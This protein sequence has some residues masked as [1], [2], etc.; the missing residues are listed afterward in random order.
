VITIA[1]ATHKGGTGKTV[2]AMGLAAAF[3]RGGFSTLLVD[4][5][6]QGHSTLGLG[7]ELQPDEPGTLRDLLLEPPAP[8]AQ[9]VRP[10]G[11]RKLAIVPSDIR[12]E[13]Q[14]QALTARTRREFV[15]SKALARLV[16]A[17]EIVVIDCPPSLGAL[18]ENGIAAADWILVPCQMEARAGDGLV[19]LLELV[20][21]LKDA[22]F[23]RWRIVY[24]KYDV[25]KAA[26]NR[27]IEGAF[28][29]YRAQ[30]VQTRIPQSEPLNQAQID[31]VD[32][33][34]FAPDSKGALAYAELAAELELLVGARTR[35]AS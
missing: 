22:E 25:R 16:P 7:V 18:T 8:I 35:A 4:L 29:R 26:T 19:D 15:L 27:I 13:R 10:T 1:I 28:E 2:T 34:A 12:V 9:V 14:A 20:A 31:R 11:V 17:P 21:E 6:P 32:V 23:D 33:F 3:A 5:D 24:T 30:T